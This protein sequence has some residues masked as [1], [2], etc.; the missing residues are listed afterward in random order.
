MKQ[1]KIR[2]S[3]SQAKGLP[4]N[5]G[6]AWRT[7]LSVRRSFAFGAARRLLGVVDQAQQSVT[8]YISGYLAARLS[9][10]LFDQWTRLCTRRELFCGVN[11][12]VSRKRDRNRINLTQELKTFC[13]SKHI[14]IQSIMLTITLSLTNVSLLL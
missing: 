6:E 11:E 4:L 7:T 9:F 8:A 12:H 13:V 3:G 2:F 5:A 10:L 14:M 1:R